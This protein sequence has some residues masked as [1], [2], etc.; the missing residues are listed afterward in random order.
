[1]KKL[2]K[3]EKKS[4]LIVDDDEII[5]ESKRSIFQSEDNIVDAAETEE[6]P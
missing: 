4:I 5:L 2:V 1:M 3:F 6:K